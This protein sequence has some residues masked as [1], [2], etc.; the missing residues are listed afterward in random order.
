M[1]A[2]PYLFS[3]VLAVAQLGDHGDWLLLPRL[4]RGQELVY[5]G[6]FAEE[7]IGKGVQFQRNYRLESRVFVLDTPPSG[8]DVAFLTV[9]KQRTAS[10]GRDPGP[11]PSSVRLEV[12]KADLQGRVTA[13]AASSLLVP[14][15]GPPTIECGAFV[16]LPHGRVALNKSWIVA[17]LGRP[18]LT[19]R[20]AGT[21]MVNGTTCLKLAG[22]QVSDDWDHPRADHAA[23]RRLETVW[24]APRLGIA[25]RV[26]R[27][28]ERREPAH[29]APS[30]RSVARYELESSL[31]YPGQLFDD[32]QR[33]I[34]LARDLH[35]AVAP[36]LPEPGKHGPQPFERMLARIQF[37]LDNQPPTPYREAIL[38][39][40]RRVEAARRGES[41][42]PALPEPAD[43]AVA[44][45]TLDKRAPDFLTPNLLTRQST[46]LRNWL[47]KPILMVFYS[48]N[49]PMSE[50]ILRFAQS[51]HDG[52]LQR[53]Q[54]LGLP[55]AED[56]PALRKQCADLGLTFPILAGK[57]LCLLYGVKA[58]PEL[59]VL[60]ADGVVRGM[61][62][63]WGPETPRAVTE[64]LHRWVHPR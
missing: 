46:T 50:D 34:L 13:A 3:C 60:D 64:E 27:I 23:W 48:P 47:G 20:V 51:V 30:Q 26:E 54:V 29:L 38:Q 32:R 9:L 31:Q 11:E 33:E 7:A 49:A 15:D 41:P 53:I 40:R 52:P 44:V 61:Y 17:E 21:E 55:V 62:V 28:I 39:V 18:A 12:A 36:L 1:V 24:L 5:R 56:S 43:A 16:E 37:H 45:A 19:W 42:P 10:S 14:L 6:S 2:I 57:G 4:G 25:Y 59:V 63:G 35:A 8:A 22:I 58:T